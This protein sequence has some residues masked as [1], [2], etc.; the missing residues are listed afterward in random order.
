ML[1]KSPIY[2]APEVQISNFLPHSFTPFLVRRHQFV[3]GLDQNHVLNRLLSMHYY[4]PI[5][6]RHSCWSEY[7]LK[8]I[9]N[10]NVFD[11]ETCWTARLFMVS[12]VPSN[13]SKPSLSVNVL[14]IFGSFFFCSCE[15]PWLLKTRIVQCVQ[16]LFMQ[17]DSR[18]AFRIK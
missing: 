16:K 3:T 4:N 7:F 18:V 14:H 9:S 15:H 5:R 2:A 13:K 11:H 1:Q 10:D 12:V 17:C 6:R 8:F